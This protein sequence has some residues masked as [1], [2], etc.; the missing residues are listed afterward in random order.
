MQNIPLTVEDL[1]KLR[2]VSSISC[3]PDGS[4]VAVAVQRLDR[5]AWYQNVL[6]FLAKHMRGDGT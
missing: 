6:G 5:V 3:S 1:V 2:R 4:W